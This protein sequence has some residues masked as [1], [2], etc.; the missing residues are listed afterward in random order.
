MRR[1][2]FNSHQN[3]VFLAYDELNAISANEREK[4]Y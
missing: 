3:F 2:Y 1:L 4:G